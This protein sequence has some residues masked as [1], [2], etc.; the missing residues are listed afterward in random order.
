[1]RA[2]LRL[3]FV[4]LLFVFVTAPPVAIP[5]AA[6]ACN[7]WTTC[8]PGSFGSWSPYYNC[9][10]TFCGY[11]SYCDNKSNGDATL[12]PR[13]RYRIYNYP[14]GSQCAEYQVISV[15]NFCGCP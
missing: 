15:R 7:G 6:S 5:A 14:D 9:D 8:P 13:E 12:Q 1:M 11:D 10:S 4:L 2:P 3:L